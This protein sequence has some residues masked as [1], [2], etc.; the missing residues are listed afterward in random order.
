LR[1]GDDGSGSPQRIK[2]SETDA[3]F[4]REDDLHLFGNLSGNG[5]EEPTPFSYDFELVNVHTGFVI[6]RRSMKRKP[7]YN[8]YKPLKNRPMIALGPNGIDAVNCKSNKAASFWNGKNFA[9]L[10]FSTAKADRSNKLTAETDAITRHRFKDFSCNRHKTFKSDGT[11]A[12][13]PKN[14]DVC[15]EFGMCDVC[16]PEYRVNDEKTG[17]VKCTDDEV[18]D[19]VTKNCVKREKGSEK[20]SFGEWKDKMLT[21][22]MIKG[23]DIHGQMMVL[24][25]KVLLKKRKA[26]EKAKMYEQ[27]TDPTYPDD[28]ILLLLNIN[29]ID[30]ETYQINLRVQESHERPFFV[31]VPVPRNAKIKLRFAWSQFADSKDY[32]GVK[33]KGFSYQEVA[34]KANYSKH[35]QVAHESVL[36]IETG[37]PKKTTSGIVAKVLDSTG[38]AITDFN[39]LTTRLMHI[40]E[41]DES[42]QKRIKDLHLNLNSARTRCENVHENCVELWGTMAVKACPKGYERVGCCKCA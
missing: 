3:I 29:D 16:M 7:G 31:S 30:V 37:T 14:C 34:Y 13:C 33:I 26:G 17:C 15:K 32:S 25:G 1:F 38:L 41:L 19:T 22:K 18:F 20:V 9:C 4:P 35:R 42:V 8:K 27:K 28:N 11:C 36:D 12:N 10:K 2:L 39:E 24:Q 21:S 40:N 23:P 6:D 5:L